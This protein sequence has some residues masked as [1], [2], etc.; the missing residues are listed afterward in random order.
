[1]TPFQHLGKNHKIA[2]P[3]TW[4]S[5]KGITSIDVLR[6]D[7]WR[8]PAQVKEREAKGGVRN[9]VWKVDCHHDRDPFR[10]KVPPNNWTDDND[11]V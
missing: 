11:D 4:I 1:M 2:E 10:P 8:Y 5:T 7:S 3:S 9:D 6:R